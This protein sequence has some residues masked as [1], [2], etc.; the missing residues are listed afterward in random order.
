MQNICQKNGSALVMQNIIYVKKMEVQVPDD[1]NYQQCV[2]KP[3]QCAFDWVNAHALKD[4][5]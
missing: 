2:Q 5:P 3:S 1:V 4:A